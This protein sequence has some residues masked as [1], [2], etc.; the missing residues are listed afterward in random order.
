MPTKK[1]EQEF[2]IIRLIVAILIALCISFLAV[3][4]VTTEPL[5]TMS[6]LLIGPLKTIRRMGNVVE[7]MI[8]LMFTGVSVSIMYSC[9]QINM[10]SEG[11]FFLGGVASSYF[12]VTFMLPR[13][14]HPI[15]C[16]I[17][18]GIAGSIICGIPALLFVR[19]RALPVVSSL[20][21]NYVALY[22][23]LFIINYIIRDP[24]AG[25]LCSY[26][27]AETAIL[28][29]LFSKTNIHFGL[30]IA[31]IVIVLGYYYL[32]RSKCG[33]SIRI[34]GKNEKF[35]KYSGIS[36]MSTIVGCQLLGGFIAGIGGAVEQLGM[37]NR[38][39]Y[40]QLSNH[41][42]D[43]VL[44]A[45]LAQYNPKFVPLAALFLAYIRVGADVMARTSDV[46]VEIVNIIQAIIII[47]VAAE[48]FL[49][50]WKHKK[51]V[52]SSQIKMQ[53]KEV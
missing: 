49:E 42:F 36:I 21:I 50:T 2:H 23:G 25:Y 12:A 51:I 37:Y 52:A 30:V 48:R 7:M 40:Q 11:A 45:I 1:I 35:A 19:N 28:P 38:F 5:E 33:Y 14:I 47:F 18:G 26:K 43:G 17:V 31:A 27:F 20:M 32:Y 4:L 53:P 44:I 10:A 46:P 34:I 13:G 29:K 3:S 6:N 22:L 24:Q 9:N 41:G 16:I 8:P 15:V 39:Q